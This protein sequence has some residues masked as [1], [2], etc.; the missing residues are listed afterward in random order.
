MSIAM[1][2]EGS[3]PVA[4]LLHAFP[5]DHHMWDEQIP[6]IVDIGW[7][8]LVPDLPGFGASPLPAEGEPDLASVVATLISATLDRGVDRLVV[9]G[10]SVGGYLTM[11][12]WRQRSEMLAGV[13]LCDTKATADSADAQQARQ[14]LAA[15]I[16]Q[17]PN[18]CAEILREKILPVLVGS[19]TH[20]SRP[21]VVRRVE[22]WML[23]VSPE[24]V[25]WYQRAMAA[26]PDSVDMLT[27]VHVP[28]LVLWGDEDGMSPLSEQNTMREAL[29]DAQASEIPGSGHLS[30]IEQPAHVGRALADFLTHIQRSGMSG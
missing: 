15:L 21:N 3:G 26:R 18:R 25:S 17:S 10:L 28:A 19:T 16:D 5:C 29:S 27:E 12:W 4:M 30:A 23:Q 24:T 8:V 11:E 1:I 2:D 20:A 13:G 6:A 14:E 7:R 22:S 9:A